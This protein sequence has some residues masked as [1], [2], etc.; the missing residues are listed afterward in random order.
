MQSVNTQGTVGRA[1]D[2][3]PTVLFSAVW[4]GNRLGFPILPGAVWKCADHTTLVV[5]RG[6]APHLWQWNPLLVP[7]PTSGMPDWKRLFAALPRIAIRDRD[8]FPIT[9]NYYDLH[10]VSDS[11]LLMSR[12]DGLFPIMQLIPRTAVTGTGPAR[13]HPT[14][15]GSTRHAREK[16]RL[17]SREKKKTH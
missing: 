15:I 6:G 13:Q 3:Q 14:S 16:K 12:W 9:E 4:F 1:G 17:E 7:G 11:L 10:R 5:D 2:H 8:G